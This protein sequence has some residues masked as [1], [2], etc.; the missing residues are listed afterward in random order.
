MAGPSHLDAFIVSPNRCPLCI[1]EDTCLP[2]DT[3]G[4]VH[5]STAVVDPTLGSNT[6][7]GKD[8]LGE[9]SVEEVGP[10][11]NNK[12]LAQEAVFVGGSGGGQNSMHRLAT[13]EGHTNEEITNQNEGIEQGAKA[14]A[15]NGRKE[16]DKEA[17][18]FSPKL[19]LAK[20]ERQKIVMEELNLQKVRERVEDG[21]ER[22]MMVRATEQQQQSRGSLSCGFSPSRNGL[23]PGIIRSLN[24]DRSLAQPC[25]SL[26]NDHSSDEEDGAASGR[27]GAIIE[28]FIEEEL[29]DND[30]D[31]SSAECEEDRVARADGNGE[32]D[33]WLDEQVA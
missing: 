7:S 12:G 8:P 9:V 6:T 29:A 11:D 21:G 20:G 19:T 3:L 17:R 13:R 2:G 18:V 24:S 1:A 16:I 14:S 22:C 10:Y 30:M 25:I 5:V 4:P 33:E 28:G 26:Q 23:R 15:V 27:S 32:C 31:D